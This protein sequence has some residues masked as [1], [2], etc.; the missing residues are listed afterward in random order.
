[1]VKYLNAPGRFLAMKSAL[2][3]LREFT[4]SQCPEEFILKGM[5]EIVSMKSDSIAVKTRKVQLDDLYFHVFG[6]TLQDVLPKE[7]DSK[8]VLL[9]NFYVGEESAE[10]RK[11]WEEAIS[12]ASRDSEGADD[13]E[14][15]DE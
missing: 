7:T 5:A 4:P 8:E 1:M 15:E 13:E 10:E 14:G 6:M 11:E 9:A 3:M 2:S 12:N